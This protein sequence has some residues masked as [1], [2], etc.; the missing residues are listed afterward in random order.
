[1]LAL[2]PHRPR[3]RRPVRDAFTLI[4]VLLVLIILVVIGSIV[5]P[6]IFTA[7]DTANVKQATAQTLALKSAIRMYRLK[8]NKYPASLNDLVTKPSDAAEAQKWGQAYLDNALAND[9]WDQPYQYANP[10]KH[11]TDSFDVWSNGP[12]GQSGTD[13]DIGN[14]TK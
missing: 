12:D 10:G 4:E 1:M 13:D 8:M 14:W 6:N 5:A 9:P 2:T 3:S 7:Q 11:N